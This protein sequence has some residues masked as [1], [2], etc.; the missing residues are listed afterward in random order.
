[1]LVEDGTVNGPAVF[2]L[3]RHGPQVKREAVLFGG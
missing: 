3:L 1:V 2:D